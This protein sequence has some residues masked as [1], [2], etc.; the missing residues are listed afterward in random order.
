[1]TSPCCDGLSERAREKR[2]RILAA[3]KACFVEKGFHGAGMAAVAE[4]AGISPGLIYRYF[5]S[6]SEIVR[7]IIDLQ[8]ERAG[9]VLDGLDSAEDLVDAM[10]EAFSQWAGSGCEGLN[11]A[12]FLEM[13]AEATRDDEIGAA[14]RAADRAVRERVEEA[15]R[16]GMQAA[17]VAPD[18]ATVRRRA[19]VFMTLVHGLAIRAV[20][21]PDLPPEV[22]RAA[23]GESVAALLQD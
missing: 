3:A 18:D 22:L 4:R 11:A 20:R 6:K 12:L 19:V 7:A 14:V 2:E 15:L 16:R 1:V 17:G 10:A 21:E 8:L 13:T 5:K 23:L 9:E